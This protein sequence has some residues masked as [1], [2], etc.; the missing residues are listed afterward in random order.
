MYAARGSR[1]KSHAQMLIKFGPGGA[2][3]FSREKEREGGCA[4]FLF[5]R[6]KKGE[7][8]RRGGGRGGVFWFL[9]GKDGEG[10]G[11]VLLF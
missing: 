3:L 10:G 7:G 2:F 4:V 11:G 1:V 9:R 5:L 8:G 6:G